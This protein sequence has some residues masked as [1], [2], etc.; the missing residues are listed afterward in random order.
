MNKKDRAD[1]IIYDISVIIC[2]YTEERWSQLIQAVASI[3]RQSIPVREIIV[4]IDHNPALLERAQAYVFSMTPAATIVENSRNRG[5]SGARNSGIALAQGKLIAFLDDDAIAEPDW[6]ERLAHGCQR[7]NVLGVGGVV[8]PLWM[9]KKPAWFPHEFYW[10][11]GCSYQELHDAIIEVRNPYGGCTCIQR[12]VFDTIGVY[13][14][15]IGRVGSHLFGGE[16]TEL[17]I[18]ATQRWPDKVFLCDPHARIHHY[19]SPARARLS[20]FL[21]RCYAEGVSKALITDH[22]G[23]KDSLASELAY[24]LVTLPKGIARGL[25]SGIFQCQPTGFLRAGAIIAGLLMTTV[26]YFA[27]HFSQ[28]TANKKIN[29]HAHQKS[30]KSFHINFL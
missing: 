6:L 11:L 18:R 17:C 14:E 24:T 22:V 16:E 7:P 3:Q 27:G 8:E 29:I 1:D 28:Y 10:V 12:E 19:I 4:V 26:G 23:A 2:A 25:I 9:V 21:K 13:C 5:L 15:E 20:Y 30:E